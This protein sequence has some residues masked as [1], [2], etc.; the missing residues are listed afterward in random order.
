MSSSIDEAEVRTGDHARVEGNR[1]SLDLVVRAQELA[2]VQEVGNLDEADFG[3][4]SLEEE[5]V[6]VGQPWQRG[7]ADRAGRGLGVVVEKQWVKVEARGRILGRLGH[8]PF[9]VAVVPGRVW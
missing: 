1:E 5:V 6:A 2:E 4:S 9:L 7:Q 3:S 8:V